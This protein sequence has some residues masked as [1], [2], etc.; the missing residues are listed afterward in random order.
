M[1]IKT[2]IFLLLFICTVNHYSFAEQTESQYMG[3]SEQ[4]IANIVTQKDTIVLGDSI[5]IIHTACAPIC[6]SHVRVYSKEWKE[7]GVI[8]APFK[9]AFPEAYIEDGKILWRDNDHFDY[10]PIP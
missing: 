7:I 8:K 3:N 9:S 10:S 6:S 4:S 1:K 2:T 5:A